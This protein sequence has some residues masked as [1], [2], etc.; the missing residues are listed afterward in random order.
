M[1]VPLLY[2]KFVER[3]NFTAQEF[4]LKSTNAL[5]DI[6]LSTQIFSALLLFS[7][8]LS[9]LF[10]FFQINDFEPVETA[11]REIVSLPALLLIYLFVV[12]VFVEEFFFR[13]FLVPRIGIAVSSIAFGLAHFGY[14]SLAEVIGAFALGAILAFAYKKSNRI[15]PNF[16]AHLLYNFVSVALV[17]MA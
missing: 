6:I 14:G 15:V 9:F 8:V 10:G 12:R 3:K 1:L 7:V 4:G 2:I 5:S 13:A 11:I 16:I 17:L